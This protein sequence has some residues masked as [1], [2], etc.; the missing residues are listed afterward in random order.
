MSFLFD[1]TSP[2]SIEVSHAAEADE[3]ER[4]V[5]QCAG[6]GGDAYRNVLYLDGHIAGLTGS[7]VS[8]Q[9]LFGNFVQPQL[10][11]VVD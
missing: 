6:A 8:S 4:G 7:S 11:Q 5:G 3:W 9:E 10:L 2:G 1:E